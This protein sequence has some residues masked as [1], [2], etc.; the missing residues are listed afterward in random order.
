MTGSFAPDPLLA[1]A[2]AR[3]Q[4]GAWPDVLEML[5]PAAAERAREPELVTL[6]G[7]ALI[8]TGRVREARL[9]LTDAE[10]R[11]AGHPDRAAHRTVVNMLGAACFALGELDDAA[12]AF[13]EAL[14][15]G[16]RSGDVLLVAR[17]SNNLGAIANLRG[18]RERA[19]WHYELAIPAYQR[20]GQSRGL[21]ESYHNLAIT[22]RDLGMLARADEC[23]RRAIEY[24]AEAQTPRMASMAR[25]GRAEIAL[26]RGD[27]LL[28]EATARRS[29]RELADSGDRAT[30]ADAHR[31][32]G[33][34][35]AAQ[36]R[37]DDARMAFAQALG[38]ARADGFALVEAET[39]RDRARAWAA[40][41]QWGA[42]R[43]DAMEALEGLRRLGAA[44]ACAELER[45]IEEELGER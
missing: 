6:L 23:E 37:I 28:A 11:L 13:E 1:T 41:G 2:R 3:A 22:Q 42:A 43:T 40:D 34:A 32:A 26:R 38:L 21:A 17:A 14:E 29:I 4:D 18:Q 33:A 8:H 35:C 9:W 44:P 36:G 5:E 25:L 12:R 10:R 20:L 15:L 39:L 7:A 19:I 24:A 16:Q 31:L 45:W 30:E 27:A